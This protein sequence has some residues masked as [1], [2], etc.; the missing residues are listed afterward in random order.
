[1]ESNAIFED[2]IMSLLMLD[3]YMIMFG[4]TFRLMIDYENDSLWACIWKMIISVLICV[5]AFPVIVAQLLGDKI[6]E[7]NKKRE[8]KK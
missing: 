4:V 2:L 8:E 1:M 3:A 7:N 5:V 6:E